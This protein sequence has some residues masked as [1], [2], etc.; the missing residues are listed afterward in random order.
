MEANLILQEIMNSVTHGLGIFI[1]LIGSNLLMFRVKDKSWHHIISCGI[2]S[3]SLLVLYTSSTLYHSFFSLLNTRYLF[4][5]FD[6]CAIYILIAGSYTP[7]LSISLHH[8]P[9]WSIYLLAF[10]WF[11]CIMGILV[12]AFMTKWKYK[13]IFSLTMYL[14]MGWCC[15]VCFPDLIT[16]IDTRAIHLLIMGGVAYTSGVPFFV[17]NH[18][19]DHSIWH[20]FVL[21]G[22]IF[23]W[24]GVYWHVATLQLDHYVHKD[25]TMSVMEMNFEL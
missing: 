22:S 9:I 18:N 15:L 13:S 21:A 7:Y 3:T 8:K 23:H 4:E 25:D 17:R 16:I 5:I 24:L 1:C 11:C 2:Y 12:E 20:C 10:I 6:H 14:C 19:L